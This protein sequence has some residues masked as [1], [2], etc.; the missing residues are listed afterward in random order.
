MLASM[1]G[2]KPGRPQ[3]V[4]IAKILGLAACQRRQPCLGFHRD[5]RLLARVTA[6]V[7]RRHGALNRRPLNAAL[8]RLMMQSEHLAHGKKRRVLPVSQQDSRSLDPARRLSSRLRYRPQLLQIRI[9]ER[10]LD[11]PPPRCHIVQSFVSK[12]HRIYGSPKPQMNPTLLTTFTESVIYSMIPKM[13]APDLIR[14][15]YRFRKRSC[16]N[17]NLERDDD[18]KK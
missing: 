18:S 1:A 8:D 3:F 17:N 5:R 2:Q 13:P 9:S 12:P 16:S 14:G 7:Q 10:Q 4:R 6:V 15:G 11:R